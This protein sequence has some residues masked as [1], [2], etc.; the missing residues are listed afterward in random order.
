MGRQRKEEIIPALPA[1]L[2]YRI[3]V[4]GACAVNADFPHNNIVPD[5]SRI[6][7]NHSYCKKGG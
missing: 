1:P 7:N 6:H 5:K 2:T 4:K 3:A